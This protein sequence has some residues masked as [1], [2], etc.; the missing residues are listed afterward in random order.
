VGRLRSRDG[1]GVKL[2]RNRTVGCWKKPGA[3]KKLRDFENEITEEL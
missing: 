2:P 3:A 1:I